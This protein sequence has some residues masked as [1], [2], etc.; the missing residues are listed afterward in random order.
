MHT[1]VSAPTLPH[2]CRHSSRATHNRRGLA[3]RR[4]KPTAMLVYIRQKDSLV[5]ALL[6]CTPDIVRNPLICLIWGSRRHLVP[7]EARCQLL[8]VVRARLQARRSTLLQLQMP[9]THGMLGTCPAR[10]RRAVT[11]ISL[12]IT[13]RMLLDIHLSSDQETLSQ[14][15]PLFEGEMESS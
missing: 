5:T 1:I 11:W 15:T 4:I 9:L 12:D 6:V 13:F 8:K 7:L 3:H 14:Y 2:P 10:P